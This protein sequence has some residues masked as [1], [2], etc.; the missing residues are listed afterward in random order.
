[1][2]M[3][4]EKIHKRKKK[5]F[6]ITGIIIP[7]FSLTFS[8][9]GPYGN[10]ILVTFSQIGARYGAIEQLIL[11]GIMSSI[12]YFFFLSYLFEISGRS[13]IALKTLLSITCMTLLITVFL[14]YAPT[15]FPITSKTHNYLAYITASSIVTL[16]LLFVISLYSL[17]KQLFIKSLIA[18]L[19]SV[20]I[21]AFVL[22]YYGVSSLF[23]IVL[24]ITM[25]ILMFVLLLFLEKCKKINIYVNIEKNFQEK[26][27]DSDIF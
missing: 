4:I 2:N 19:V 25:C 17:D 11:W 8:Y 20:L 3:N 5:I 12:Y 27:N 14:P 10:L 21:V 1:M 6:A 16:L 23:Q 18:Y 15:M 22:F 24:S 13:S 26:P 7:L 9:K